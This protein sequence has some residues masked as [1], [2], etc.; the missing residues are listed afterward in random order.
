MRVH[1]NF[2]VM[3]VFDRVGETILA[4]TVLEERRRKMEKS[5]KKIYSSSYLVGVW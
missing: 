2:C 1:A 4:E 5:V 3:L